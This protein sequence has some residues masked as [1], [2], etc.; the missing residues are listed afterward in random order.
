VAGELDRELPGAL[1]VTRPR[2]DLVDGALDGIRRAS[3]VPPTSLLK[4][5]ARSE[6]APLADENPGM[7]A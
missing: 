2:E 4:I 3:L 5:I 1:T 6:R 7:T